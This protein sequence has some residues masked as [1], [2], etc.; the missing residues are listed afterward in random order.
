LIPIPIIAVIL[1]LGTPKARS[2][3]PAFALGWV[4]GLAAVSVVVLI[5]ARGASDPETTSSPSVN[6]ITLGIGV[7]FILGAKLIGSGLSGVTR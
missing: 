7:L 1:L 2:N 3:G 6:S 4:V 5:I